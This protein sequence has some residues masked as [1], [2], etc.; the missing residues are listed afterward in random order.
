M[1]INN[2]T[3]RV[4]PNLSLDYEQLRKVKSESI[5]L[6]SMRERAESLGGTLKID[7]RPGQGTRII[8]EV[9]R[10]DKDRVNG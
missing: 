9:P 6:S 3:P 1:V 10:A 8:I 4:M 7:S 5:G 2:F